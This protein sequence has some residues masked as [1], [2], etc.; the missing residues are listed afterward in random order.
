MRKAKVRIAAVS[1]ALAWAGMQLVVPAAKADSPAPPIQEKDVTIKR[2]GFGISQITLP[3][4]AS[5][6]L[7][8]QTSEI[9]ADRSGRTV[10]PYSSIIYDLDGASWVYSVVAPRTYV[11]K[12][13][14]IELIKGNEAYLKSGPPAGTPVVTVGVVQLYGTEVGV[15]G[16]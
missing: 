13:V 6:R 8:I 4:K 9:R 15:N 5:R 7:N 1:L 12:E 14:E 11:R 3:E 16:E 10:A 2:L